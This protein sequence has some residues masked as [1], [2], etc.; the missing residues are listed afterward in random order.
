MEEKKQIYRISFT[1]DEIRPLV[2]KY[3]NEAQNIKNPDCLMNCTTYSIWHNPLISFYKKCKDKHPSMADKLAFV[4][5]LSYPRRMIEQIKTMSELSLFGNSDDETDFIYNDKLVIDKSDDNFGDDA[6]GNYDCI[7]SYNALCYVHFVQN[8]HSGISLVVGSECIHKHKLLSEEEYKK[9]IKNDKQLKERQQEIKEGKPIG[10]IQE[11]KRLK[12]EEKQKEKIKK[13]EE[14]I[15]KQEEKERIRLEN[16]KKDEEI[17]RYELLKSGNFHICKFCETNIIT[18]NL[19]YCYHCV[20]PIICKIKK[21][22]C[23]IIEE[24]GLIECLNCC[25][26]CID[27]KKEY[28]LC[29]LCNKTNTIIKCPTTACNTFMIVDKYTSI[30]I[31]CDDCEKKILKCIDCNLQ[32]ISNNVNKLN[33]DSCTFNKS[34]ICIN[35]NCVYCNKLFTAKQIDIWKKYCKECYKIIDG[36][37][38]NPSKC[39]CNLSMV[40]KTVK[41]NGINKG[42]IGLACANFPNGCNKFNMF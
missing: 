3:I 42:R 20:S 40:K 22:E 39:K 4:I 10:F 21:I 24:Y 15:K 7:C 38:L 23:Q 28:Y 5:L 35:I 41:K 27:K 30:I 34:N 36:L 26:K 1:I 2:F 9:V 6:S 31:Y 11:K 33:C 14:K 32:F 18:I 16:E 19:R 37:T 17:C 8:K 29:A 12:K 25:K 13:Q